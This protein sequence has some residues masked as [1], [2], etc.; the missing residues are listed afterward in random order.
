MTG[1]EDR[2]VLYW[3]S[4]NLPVGIHSQCQPPPLLFHPLYP[5]FAFLFFFLILAICYVCVQL[6]AD[7]QGNWFYPFEKGAASIDT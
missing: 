3:V 2:Q 1:Q 4:V 5:F 6:T 7:A